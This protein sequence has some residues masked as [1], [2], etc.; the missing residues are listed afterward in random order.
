VTTPGSS[1]LANSSSLWVAVANI[2]RA[3]LYGSRPPPNDSLWA[4]TERKGFEVVVHDPG[5]S[6]YVPTIEKLRGDRYSF[7]VLFWELA[8]KELKACATAFSPLNPQLQLLR[9][10]LLPLRL[11][12]EP[13]SWQSAARG[14]A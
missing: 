8:A 3:V 12:T 5:D 11:L 1:I 2:G 9:L 10:Q 13:W 7:Y 14:V 4:A 6:D